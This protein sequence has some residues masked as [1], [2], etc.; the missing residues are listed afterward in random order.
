MIDFKEVL[1]A[2]KRID[3][4]I[5]KTPLEK[6]M[7][8]SDKDMNI[9]LK[10]ENQ[11][12]MKCAKIRGAFN[13]II[14]LNK[15]QKDKGIAAISSGNHGAAVSYAASLLGIDNASIYVPTTTPKSKVE[16]I[17]YYGANIEK[18]GINFDE[19][20]NIGLE[21]IKESGA[22]FIDPC[23]DELVIAG[24]GT[25]GL[26]ILEDNPNIDAILVPIGGGGIITGISVAAKTINPDI[27]IIGLQTVA[28]PAMV[29]SMKENRYYQ[30]YPS[31]ESIC[32]ALVGGVGYIPYKMSK[33]YIDDILLVEEEDI[34][35]AVKHL[36]YKE[37]VVVE[38]A[39]AIG[40]AAVKKNSELFKDKNIA[41]VLTGGNL[42]KNS[43]DNLN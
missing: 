17:E 39:G 30:V 8:L 36:L 6:S 41:V 10:L 14:S 19:A 40:V 26:E 34:L 31:K 2:K 33:D 5:Y 15:G 35:E 28:C 16:K 29:A 42:D 25:I 13:K 21:K 32:D 22:T 12:K 18:L 7:Y 9:Y 38:P 3:K 37:K 1:K 11:Q 27:K 4:Y 24:Q 23:S 20:N 43:I